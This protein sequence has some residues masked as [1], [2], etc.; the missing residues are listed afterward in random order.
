MVVLRLNLRSYGNSFTILEAKMPVIKL[1]ST[2]FYS[3]LSPK[4]PGTCGSL[5]ALPFVYV[6]AWWGGVTAVA[7]FAL[8]V[9]VAGVYVADVYAKKLGQTDP[10][11]IVVDEVAGQAIALL[12]AGT[13]LSLF[14]L[15]FGLF[16]LFDITKPWPVSWADQKVHGG[17]G[18][19][20]DDIFAGI[21]GGIILW[22]IK[23]YSGWF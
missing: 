19:M 22:G 6:L 2:W 13:N 10:G 20:L 11:R 12:A 15:G 14:V 3:G 5:A 21:I 8:V 18:I 9:S 7:V 17:L 16:R 23:T 4:A 1:I